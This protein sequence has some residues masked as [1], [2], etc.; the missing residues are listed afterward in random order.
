MLEI[1]MDYDYI[2]IGAGSAGCV[3]ANRLSKNPNNKVLLIEAGPV[4]SNFWIHIP[5][6]FG[7]NI[8]NPDVNWCYQGEPEP[9][10]R[11]KAYFLPRGRVLGGSSSIN[12]MVYVRGQVEDFDHW[13]QLG[14]RGWSFEDVLPYF[15]KSEDNSR[16]MSELRGIGGPLSVSDLSETNNLCDALIKAGNEIG[17]PQTEDINGIV[18]EGIGYH[19]ATI[20][21][22]RRCSAAIAFLNPIKNRPNLRI[23]TDAVAQ[24]ILFDGKEAS[25]IIYIRGGVL[26]TVNAK[27]EIILSGGAFNSPQLLELSGIGQQSVL[28]NVGIPIVHELNGVGHALQDHQIIRMRWRILKAATFNEQVHGWRAVKSALNYLFRRSGVLSMPTLPISAFTRTRKELSTPD[29]QI[30][31]FPGTYENLEARKLD[32][33][34]GITLGA[35]LL[36]PESRG[37]V[38]VRSSNPIKAP[39]IFHNLLETEGDRSTAVSAMKICRQLMEATPMKDFLGKEL[40]PGQNIN[41]EDE[42][43]E[44]ARDIVQSNWHPTSTCRMG[45][46]KNAVVD[47]RLRVHGLGK[48]RVADASIMPTTVSGNTNAATIMIGEKAADMILEDSRKQSIV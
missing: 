48:L 9:Y 38:H 24:K 25:G 22:G 1:S 34:P 7:K 26:Q 18:Q 47:Q 30:Q 43:L 13:A 44:S 45:N 6:G 5:L 8:N 3:L 11:D 21:K 42:L 31:V 12:G 36:R 46:D 35:T 20:R 27:C 32:V 28:K 29:L 19:Q 37:W 14:N 4:D 41:S 33:D 40:T 2:I 15:K 39:A 17:I 10:C 23:E 16:G